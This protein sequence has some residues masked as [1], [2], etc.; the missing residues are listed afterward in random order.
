MDQKELGKLLVRIGMDL[1]S[2]TETRYAADINWEYEADSRDNTSWLAI[3]ARL[4]AGG[5]GFSNPILCQ[6]LVR[7]IAE[8][9]KGPK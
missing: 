4:I 3:K 8:S 5:P 7:K 6:Q 1:V 9:N 2:D